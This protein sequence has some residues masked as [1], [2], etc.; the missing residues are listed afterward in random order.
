MKD[1]K[2]IRNE[3]QTFVDAWKKIQEDNSNAPVKEGYKDVKKMLKTNKKGYKTEKVLVRKSDAFT[4]LAEKYDMAPKQFARYV[5]ANQHLFDIPT[6]KKA[7]L[8]NK[9]QGFKE[10]KEWDEFFGDLE[11]VEGA[12]YTVNKADKTG[13]T[14]AYQNYKKGMLNKLTGKPLY[15][16]GV[17]LEKASYEPEGEELQEITT[18]DTKSGTK[19]KVRVKDKK[20]NSSYIRFAT[21]DKIAQLRSDPKIA[22]VEMTDEGQTPEERGEKKAQAAGGGSMKKAK[23]DYDGDGKVESGTAEYMGSKDKAIKKA[24]KKR[25][26]TTEAQSNWREDLKEIMGEVEKTEGKKSKSKKVKNGVCINPDTDDE[27]NKYEEAKPMT[28]VT[29][30]GSKL[31]PRHSAGGDL[32]QYDKDGKPKRKSL[33]KVRGTAFKGVREANEVAEN[34]G[35]QLKALEIE[36]ADGKVAYE[37]ID[38]VKPDPMKENVMLTYKSGQGVDAKIGGKSVRNTIN[39]V[40]T[41]V[42]A[43]KNIKK[44]G[45]VSGI[46]N[47]INKNNSTSKTSVND[48]VSSAINTYK[49]S[50][51]S[52]HELDGDV[53]SEVESTNMFPPGTQ[54]KVKKVLDKGS[55]IIKKIPVLNTIFK[56][57][58]KGSDYTPSGKVAR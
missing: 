2:T 1:S 8:A 47:T 6:R 16:A 57:K 37:V 58:N 28:S 29:G 33:N 38:L 13:N 36:D 22:S 3:H 35:G 30:D 26:V 20:S 56:S 55:S 40:K 49:S 15:K 12:P 44:D 25:S 11:L 41:G 18:K 32:S 14:P 4:A 45:L 24:M 39:N 46:K 31:S 21:R 7:V 5:E 19:F 34:L 43:I 53:I 17:G 51:K 42:N 10:N 23:K 54:E 48:K 27:K 50:L 9:F 52:S